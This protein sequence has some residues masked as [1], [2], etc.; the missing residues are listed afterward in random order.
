MPWLEDTAVEV[1]H[2]FLNGEPLTLNEAYV[3]IAH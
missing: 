1:L 3:Y 2:I